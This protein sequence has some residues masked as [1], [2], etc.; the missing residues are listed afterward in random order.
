MHASQPSMPSHPPIS[1]LLYR[2]RR[3]VGVCV[4][5]IWG[6]AGLGGLARAQTD[7]ALPV[8][9]DPVLEAHVMRIASELR[10]LVCQNQ[11]IADSN[12][13][14][15]Q[16]LRKQVRDMLRR[17]QTETQIADYMTA[18]YGDFVH[19]RPPHQARTWVL[20]WGPAL[21]AGGGLAALV[22]VLRR[23][24]R[25]PAD[26]FDPDP[27]SVPPSTPPNFP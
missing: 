25:M 21:L 19:Y 13:D 17:G 23:R 18:R 15:A 9:A 26:W 1:R 5:G 16:D 4:L 20:W 11:S 3:F 27:A 22:L 6:L 24:S 2:L 12:A 14:L 10:C 8:A 7:E